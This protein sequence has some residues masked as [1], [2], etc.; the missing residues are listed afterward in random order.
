VQQVDAPECCRAAPPVVVQVVVAVAIVIV[1]RVFVRV[2]DDISVSVFVSVLVGIFTFTF[3]AVI[4]VLAVWQIDAR[5]FIPRT[6]ILREVYLLPGR[7]PVIFCSIST[8]LR[9]IHSPST[10]IRSSRWSSSLSIGV[11][12]NLSGPVLSGA[13]PSSPSFSESLLPLWPILRDR[14]VPSDKR[15]FGAPR[16]CPGEELSALVRRFG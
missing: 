10:S 12:R 15:R 13:A 16:P 9:K 8:S 6:E 14:D 3:V 4:P 2:E 1:F 5:R 11:R 7:L